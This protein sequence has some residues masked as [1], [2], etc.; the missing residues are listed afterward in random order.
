MHA[1]ERKARS[2]LVAMGSGERKPSI[3]SK[4]CSKPGWTRVYRY[5][6]SS[7]RQH[8][9]MAVLV[10]RSNLG[11]LAVLG[12]WVLLYGARANGSTPRRPWV[13]TASQESPGK[14]PRLETVESV[15]R[16]QILRHGAAI[17]SSRGLLVL[18]GSCA[19]FGKTQ[20]APHHQILTIHRSMI[21][22]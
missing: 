19:P 17:G 15:W 18:N 16:L 3:S 7:H 21:N 22:M 11:Y 5:L 14:S 13:A 10:L 12:S 8:A 4:N 2:A 6:S 1:N 9:S 20:F